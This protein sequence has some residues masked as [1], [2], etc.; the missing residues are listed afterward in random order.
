MNWRAAVAFLIAVIP[1]LPGYVTHLTLPVLLL[2][3]VSMAKAVNPS[4]SISVGIEHVYD[5]NYLY[6]FVSSWVVY[7]SLSHF[8]PA[9]ET[10]LQACIYEDLESIDGVE[11]RNDGVHTPEIVSEK[12]NQTSLSDRELKDV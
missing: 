9:E 2:T 10:L 12:Y 6:G 5:L 11:Y 4:I 3:A 8:F 7:W 1:N